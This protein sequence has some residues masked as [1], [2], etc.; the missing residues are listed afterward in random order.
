MSVKFWD[1]EWGRFYDTKGNRVDNI[2]WYLTKTVKE[3]F[4][5]PKFEA[6]RDFALF[7]KDKILHEPPL[8]PVRTGE[9]QTSMSFF[10]GS[11]RVATTRND[12]PNWYPPEVL[13]GKV[14][15][16]RGKPVRYRHHDRTRGLDL[17]IVI[18]RKAG[19]VIETGRRKGKVL[20]F[21]RPLAGA[22]CVRSKIIKYRDKLIDFIKKYQTK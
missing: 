3:E 10:V 12:V 7:L 8:P 16:R 4:I 14:K 5:E 20:N 21:R 1:S 15:R 13:E 17:A 9:F 22:F 18:H 2:Y 11:R 6:L 19:K